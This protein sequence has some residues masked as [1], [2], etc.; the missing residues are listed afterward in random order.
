MYTV[1]V[2]R[3][4]YHTLNK[5]LR[6]FLSFM[7]WYTVNRLHI[8]WIYNS[9]ILVKTLLR[10]LHKNW[11]EKDERKIN[12]ARDKLEAECYVSF[13]DH[14]IFCIIARQCF[15]W[16]NKIPSSSWCACMKPFETYHFTTG[17][18]IGHTLQYFSSAVLLI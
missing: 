8:K 10:L 6:I 15:D 18:T 2:L 5:H 14:S 3:S 7:Y 4:W 16:F 1:L 13:W 11:H 12:I 9:H 17:I